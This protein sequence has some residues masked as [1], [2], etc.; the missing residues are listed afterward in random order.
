MTER[1]KIERELILDILAESS[2][3]RV[4]EDD[5][6]VDCIR[7]EVMD[8]AKRLLLGTDTVD[9]N[10][11]AQTH[12]VQADP[13]PE[14]DIVIQA[15]EA[16]RLNEHLEEKKKQK[17]YTE[18]KESWGRDR[19]RVFIDGKPV[20]KK[21]SECRQVPRDN[22]RGGL[23]WTWKWLGKD[24]KQEQC[25]AMWAEHEAGNAE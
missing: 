9:E 23:P 25:D 10:G 11:Y 24:Y 4:T 1:E 6:D 7:M 20:W 16:S 13:A 5:Q 3:W 19:V 22:S 21:R 14:Q 17:Q 2:K 15:I 12:Q 18:A 8:R